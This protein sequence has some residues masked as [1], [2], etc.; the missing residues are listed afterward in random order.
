ML[1]REWANGYNMECRTSK[2]E[3]RVCFER[4]LTY[5]ATTTKKL[6][7]V[8]FHKEVIGQSIIMEVVLWLES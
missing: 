5:L 7:R 3:I 6:K 8:I 4:R 2:F 1:I